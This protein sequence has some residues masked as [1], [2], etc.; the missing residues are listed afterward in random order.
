MRVSIWKVSVVDKTGHSS[1]T[2]DEGRMGEKSENSIKMVAL[3]D[4]EVGKTCLLFS[5]AKNEFPTDYKVT[6]F[7][8][9]NLKLSVNGSPYTVTVFDTAGQEEYRSH[10]CLFHCR[11]F[12]SFNSPVFF[13]HA[14]LSDVKNAL[15][16]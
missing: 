5:Y 2:V 16:G 14:F 9:Y 11:R 6:V 3:G 10:P 15:E 1:I 13:P 4:G 12:F 7:E 8:T